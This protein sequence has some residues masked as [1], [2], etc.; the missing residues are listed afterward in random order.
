M[1]LTSP[2]S[3]PGGYLI[4]LRLLMQNALCRFGEKRP[5]L[6]EEY[7]QSILSLQ[8]FILMQ[9]CGSPAG[10]KFGGGVEGGRSV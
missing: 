9:M 6:P 5:L 1:Q 10:S 3:N 4:N 7:G 8:L 2:V